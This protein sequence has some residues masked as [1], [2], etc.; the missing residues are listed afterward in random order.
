MALDE[1][2]ADSAPAEDIA[3]TVEVEVTD[4][5]GGGGSQDAPDQSPEE[6]EAALDDE[7]RAVY[8]KTNRERAADGRF[9][10]KDSD[11]SPTAKN[12]EPSP[13]ATAIPVPKSWSAEVSQIWETL[14]PKAQEFLAKRDQESNDKIYQQGRELKA[15]EPFGKILEQARP[16]FEKYGMSEGDGFAQLLRANEYLETDARSAIRDLARAYGVEDVLAGRSATPQNAVE[17]SLRAEL[18]ELRRQQGEIS[19]RVTARERSEYERQEAT[20]QTQI[21]E[22]AKD[23]PDFDTLEE[24]IHDQIVML[25]QKEPG[26]PPTEILNKAYDRAR[27]ANPEARAKVLEEQ[28]KAKEAKRLEEAK[29]R[30]QDAKRIAPLNVKGS[31]A[32]SSAARSWDDDLRDAYRRSASR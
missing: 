30:S 12:G 21:A 3:S 4:A 7:L 14:P 31:T 29:K 15:Y 1:N 20:I 19:H 16:V 6:A 32:N 27:W 28:E 8:A 2:G 10:A 22:F 24:D 26:L 11:Q 18:A 23:K 5:G 25:K 9:A 17:A 13:T